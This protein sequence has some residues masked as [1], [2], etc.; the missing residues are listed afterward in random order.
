MCTL[1]YNNKFIVLT[2]F[3]DLMDIRLYNDPL[4]G[5]RIVIYIQDRQ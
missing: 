4:P 3:L 5:R 1:A 2:S